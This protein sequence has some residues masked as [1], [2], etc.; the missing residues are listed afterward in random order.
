MKLEK[1][2]LE[3]LAHMVRDVR[4]EYSIKQL[5][6]RLKKPY[7]KVH[8]SIRRLTQKNI[9][10]KRIMGKSHY[11]RIDYKNNLD[12]VCFIEAQRTRR[13]LAEKKAVRILIENIRENLDLPDYTLLIFGSF[14]KNTQTRD[15][16]IDM[17]IIAPEA[18]KAERV[19][20]SIARTSQLAVHSVEFT[21]DDFIEMLKE[22]VLSVGK[23]IARNHIIIHGC[24]QFYECMGSAE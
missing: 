21:Y 8:S 13:F 16:D 24:E 23:E 9:I 10:Q 20:S 5:A 19:M 15:S 2:D 7:V 18:G 17:A 14:A 3:V 22:K 1:T 6:D 12:I 11:C 4:E